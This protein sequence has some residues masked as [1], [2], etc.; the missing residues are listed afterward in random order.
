MSYLQSLGYVGIGASDTGAWRQFGTTVV[1]LGVSAA[2]ED[3]ADRYWMDEFSYRLAIHQDDRDDIIYAGW[4]VAGEAGLERLTQRLLEIGVPWEAASADDRRV[5]LVTDFVRFRDPND[6]VCEAFYGPLTERE[7]MYHGPSLRSKF[8]TGDQGLGH[9][10]LAV[11]DMKANLEFYVEGLGFSFSD[12][13]AWEINGGDVEVHFVGCG[14]RHHSLALA[15]L[16]LGRKLAHLMLE[17]EDIDGVGLAM[18][19]AMQAQVPIPATLGRHVNDNVVSF[20]MDT[21]SGFQ[22]EFGCEGR[23]VERATWRRERHREGSI[24]GHRGPLMGR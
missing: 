24:W 18:D 23:R 14:P 6:I 21:P 13:L 19:A 5:R 9:L 20:Y 2:G 3:R 17:V 16:S 10:A 11:D 15:P 4:E 1:G 8:V 22:I 12:T 7:R